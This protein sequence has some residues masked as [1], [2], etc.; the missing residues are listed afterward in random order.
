MMADCIKADRDC[1]EMCKLA[2]TLMARESILAKAHCAL[3][4]RIFRACG[5]ECGEHKA[6]HCQHCAEAWMAY[7]ASCEAVAA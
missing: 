1:A 2:A 7:A 3:C 6:D 5:E 4:A